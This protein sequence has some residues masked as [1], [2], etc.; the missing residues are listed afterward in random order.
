MSKMTQPTPEQGQKTATIAKSLLVGLMLSVSALPS[1]AEQAAEQV[2]PAKGTEDQSGAVDKADKSKPK[3]DVIEQIVVTGSR[4]RRPEL[5]S[6]LPLLTVTQKDVELSGMASITDLFAQMTGFNGDSF[7]IDDRSANNIGRQNIQIRGLGYS[8]TLH[9]IDGVRMAGGDT[10]GVADVSMIPTGM[11]E[12][13]EVAK[14]A[15]SAIYGSDAIA[16]VIN[17]ILLKDY[18]GIKVKVRTGLSEKGDAAKNKIGIVAG[19]QFERGGFTIGVEFDD[20][21]TFRR[22]D[23]S[24]YKTDHRGDTNDGVNYGDD[25]TSKYTPSGTFV[26]YNKVSGVNTYHYNHRQ[27]GTDGSQLSDYDVV[28]GD[29]N[30]DWRKADKSAQD[31]Y[32]DIYGYNF[33]QD[34]LDASNRR[35]YN[36]VFNGYYS[37]TDNLE[38]TLQVMA[39]YRDNFSKEAPA[40]INRLRIHQ[41]NPYNPFGRR[42]D[43][44]RRLISET[45]R[46]TSTKT[47]PLHIRF[48]LNGNLSDKWEWSMDLIHSK[49]TADRTYPS[50]LNYD[51]LKKAVGNPLYCLEAEG[52]TPL[53]VF[54]DADQLDLESFRVTGLS[55]ISKGKTNAAHFDV[56]GE[57][58][59]LPAGTMQLAVGVEYRGEEVSRT[60]DD[61]RSQ[62]NLVGNLAKREDVIPPKRTVKEIYMETNVPLLTDAPLAKHLSVEFALRH[63]SYNDAGSKTVPSVNLYWKPVEELLFRANYAEGFRA[64]TLWDLHRGAVYYEERSFRNTSDPCAGPDWEEFELC[65]SFGGQ[66]PQAQAYEWGFETGGNLDLKPESA[67]SI[68]L[69][70]VWTPEYIKGFTATFD[71]WQADIEGDPARLTRIMMRENAR[72]NGQLFGD[73]IERNPDTHVIEYYKSIPINIGEREYSGW[74]LELNYRSAET[75]YGQFG[76]NFKWSHMIKGRT[77]FL[78]DSEWTPEAGRF[79]WIPNKQSV[80]LYW[81]KGKWRASFFV[82]RGDKTFNSYNQDTTYE[83]TDLNDQDQLDLARENALL[84]VPSYNNKYMNIGYDAGKY[85]SFN[86]NIQNPFNEK[87]K[88]YNSSVGYKRGPSP[89]GRYFTLSWSKKL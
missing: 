17:Y 18:D 88:F 62:Y 9:L 40:V 65:R 75:D 82:Y 31:K 66:I 70:V 71:Y 78:G 14:G 12:R 76:I 16:G 1:L 3:E 80:K 19:K 69:G 15:S 5:T 20:I 86:L 10:A 58:W 6:A 77:Q 60:F 38:A 53:N 44:Y 41:N 28:T 57:L 52:C 26:Y 56:L 11:L 50:T 74:D 61:I 13:V 48:G 87:P 42:V 47:K 85:G 37:L 8:R 21:N 45:E 7:S 84:W 63:S 27:E 2:T 36:A 22:N 55:D 67:K 54:V 35:E 68:N 59:D 4:L 72:T 73:L 43:M 46:S 33:F 83:V 23:R 29:P 34:S 25:F 32:I 51:A 81:N 49:I 24:F 39:S 64:P 79:N 30:T 89:R